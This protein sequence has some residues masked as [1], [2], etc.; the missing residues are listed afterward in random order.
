[1]EQVNFIRTQID[2]IANKYTIRLD[3]PLTTSDHFQE[4]LATLRMAGANDVVHILLNGPGGS[5]SVMKAF[6]NTMAQ[7]EAHIITEIEGQCCSALTMIFLAGNEFRVSD[8][9][10]FMIHTASFGYG[11]KEN[12]V[13]QYVE[14][15]AKANSRLMHKYYKNYLTEE[16]IE[17]CIEGKDFWMDA[18]EIR[19]R[20]SKR[21]KVCEQ[22]LI[23]ESKETYT[24][25]F[26][27]Q[28]V[29]ADILEDCTQFDYSIDEILDMVKGYSNDLSGE[30]EPTQSQVEVDDDGIALRQ[31][32]EGAYLLFI[33]ADGFIYD[34][35]SDPWTSFLSEVDTWATGDLK[36]YADVLG[37]KYTHNMKRETLAKR[38]DEKVKEIVDSMQE[39]K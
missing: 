5:D 39:E 1:M 31:F 21:D 25:E 6:L 4:E 7:S 24:P 23:E 20:L 34:N 8:D 38:L 30:D 2:V 26:Y 13:R 36:S 19:D 15:N 3:R 33:S 9:S 28:S 22:R 11:G 32:G 37:V 18:E 16:E 17:E 29:F 12:N 27:A 35:E 14:F 10:E